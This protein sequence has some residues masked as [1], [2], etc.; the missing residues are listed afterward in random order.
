MASSACYNFIVFGEPGVGKTCFVDQYSFSKSFVAYN[1]DDSVGMHEISID[2]RSVKMT[3]MDLSTSFLEPENAA[4]YPEWAEKMLKEAD[5]IVLL[6]NVTN[7]ES[8][9]YITRQAYDFLWRCRRLG[10]KTVDGVPEDERQSFG[11]VLAGNKLDLVNAKSDARTVDQF[12]AEDW[13]YTQGFRSIELNSL[14]RS[15]PEQ[16]LKLLVKNVWKLEQLGLMKLKENVQQ[17]GSTG[18]KGTGSS[19]RLTVRDALRTTASRWKSSQIS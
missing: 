19:I 11:C 12:L 17:A 5:G 16:A 10:K 13:A 9:E 14:A 18:A 4:E 15:G 2:G 1:P 8:F 3:L 6:Y 7:L